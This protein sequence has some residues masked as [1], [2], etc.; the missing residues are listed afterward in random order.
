VAAGDTEKEVKE[1]RNPNSP[2]VAVS[3]NSQLLPEVKDIISIII[4]KNNLV[5]ASGHVVP[6]AR[7]S[8]SAKPKRRV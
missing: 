7:C 3:K 6:D 2:F 5:L 8:R 4:A 1:S